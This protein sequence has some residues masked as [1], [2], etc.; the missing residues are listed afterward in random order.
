[1][2]REDGRLGERDA[3]V[4]RE[5]DE[6]VPEVVQADGLDALAVEPGRV[7]RDVDR[8]ERVPPRLRWRQGR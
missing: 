7:A 3:G 8:A 2:P 1:V 4:E 6:G 5:R